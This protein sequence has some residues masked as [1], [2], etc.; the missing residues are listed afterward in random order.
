MPDGQYDDVYDDS[1]IWVEDDPRGG[2]HYE[3]AP[4]Y[5]NGQRVYNVSGSTKT[6]MEDHFEYYNDK[7][8]LDRGKLKAYGDTLEDN[9][10]LRSYINDG[11]IYRDYYSPEDLYDLPDS[12]A[13]LTRPDKPVDRAAR[14]Y[15]QYETDDKGNEVARTVSVDKGYLASTADV[16]RWEAYLDISGVYNS[17]AHVN[18]KE[19]KE[20]AELGASWSARDSLTVGR[21]PSGIRQVRVA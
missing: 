1:Q 12:Y 14:S 20:A 5:Q 11:G 7:G 21:N 3:D 4:G 13:F 10:H 17:A 8:I 18:I 19:R 6:R 2:G 15:T 9:P 16:E